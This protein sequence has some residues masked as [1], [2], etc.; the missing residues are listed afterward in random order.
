MKP[1]MLRLL[2]VI[3]ETFHLPTRK[4]LKHLKPSEA[5]DVKIRSIPSIVDISESKH[6]HSVKYDVDIATKF[7]VYTAM[8]WAG[9]EVGPKIFQLL[10]I[11]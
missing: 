4:F 9:S 10:S 5:A 1:L 6:K 2:P 8:G 7:I 3:I 11:V